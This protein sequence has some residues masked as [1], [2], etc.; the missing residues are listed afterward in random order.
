MGDLIDSQMALDSTEFSA[1]TLYG[2]LEE[3]AGM[4]VSWTQ[5]RIRVGD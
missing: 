1:S 2:L 3:D 5:S 4:V